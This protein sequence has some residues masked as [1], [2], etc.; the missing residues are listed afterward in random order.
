MAKLLPDIDN[1]KPLTAGDHTEKELLLQLQEGLPDTYTVFHHLHVTMARAVSDQHGELDVVVMN[2]AGD[3]AA[4]EI[5][6]GE[7]SLDQSGAFTRYGST[8]KDVAHQSRRQFGQLLERS[9]S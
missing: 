9:S 1:F 3:L 5:K 7:L 8:V 2:R 4:L 6:A